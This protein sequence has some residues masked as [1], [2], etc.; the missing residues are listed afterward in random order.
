MRRRIIPAPE[1]ELPILRPGV[2]SALIAEKVKLQRRLDEAERA[3]Q[4]LT[5]AILQARLCTTMR[6][7]GARA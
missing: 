2:R 7:L 5:S 3:G 4:I 1:H 6:R